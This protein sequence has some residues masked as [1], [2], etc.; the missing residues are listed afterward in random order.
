MEMRRAKQKVDDF[1]G[2][3]KAT[4]SLKAKKM[5]GIGKLASPKA[6]LCIGL[7]LC[8]FSTAMIFVISSHFKE[9]LPERTVISTDDEY[10]AD[11]RQK[12]VAME[13][14]GTAQSSDVKDGQPII[15]HGRFKDRSHLKTSS[16]D[17]VGT[18]NTKHSTKEVGGDSNHADRMNMKMDNYVLLQ[19]INAYKGSRFADNFYSC[20]K[21]ILKR[22]KIDLTFLLTVD[23]LSK[24][25][26]EDIFKSVAIELNMQ[27]VPPRTYFL[28]G[29]VNSKVYPYTKSLQVSMLPAKIPGIY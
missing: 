13:A 26:A 12:D 1:A 9:S 22:T 7:G 6:G 18:N 16:K 19:L 23:E 29:E 21:S 20:I 15:T 25:T 3:Q 5:F 27:K 14:R 10:H 17:I 8:I 24:T 11:N 4:A 2:K 28:I